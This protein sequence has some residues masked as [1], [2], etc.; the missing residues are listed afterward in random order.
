MCLRNFQ[1]KSHYNS[2]SQEYFSICALHKKF[3][4]KVHEKS[5][6]KDFL[7]AISRNITLINWSVYSKEL[8]IF[9]LGLV[10]TY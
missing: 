8:G 5:D 2:T 3:M 7:N 9:V 1:D 4:K 10:M 6:R